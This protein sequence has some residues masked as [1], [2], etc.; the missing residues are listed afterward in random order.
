MGFTPPAPTVFAPPPPAL[1]L[2]FGGIGDRVRSDPKKCL[3]GLR[4]G[5]KLTLRVRVLGGAKEAKYPSDHVVEWDMTFIKDAP[6]PLQS[7]IVQPATSNRKTD[8]CLEFGSMEVLNTLMKEGKEAKRTE[9]VSPLSL[10]REGKLRIKGNRMALF[11]L[12][13]VFTGQKR[14]HTGFVGKDNDNAAEEAGTAQ[15]SCSEED[16]N[17]IMNL[18]DTVGNLRQEVEGQE[19]LINKMLVI[20]DLESAGITAAMGIWIYPLLYIPFFMVICLVILL[21]AVGYTHHR[22]SPV[23]W[24][25]FILIEAVA[26]YVGCSSPTSSIR[27]SLLVLYVFFRI[28]FRYKMAKLRA[29]SMPDEFS[30]AFWEITHRITAEE[31]YRSILIVQGLY[32]KLGQAM[33]GRADI[34]PKPFTKQL[35]KLQDCLGQDSKDHVIETLQHELKVKSYMDI[36]SDF[37]FNAVASASI[38]QV[39]KARL[40][41]GGGV[42]A[43]KLQHKGVEQVMKRDA[44]LVKYLFRLTGWAFPKQKPVFDAITEFV[45]RMEPELDFTQEAECLRVANKTIQSAGELSKRVS[46]PYPVEGLVTRRVLV[47]DWIQASRVPNSED[48]DSLDTEQRLDVANSM[49]YAFAH[50]MLVKGEFMCDPH[51]GNF[52]VKPR[53]LHK[54]TS[55]NKK[56]PFEY[57]VTPSKQRW[58]ED[59]KEGKSGSFDNNNNNNNNTYDSDSSSWNSTRRSETMLP[60]NTGT[61][62]VI[63][64]FGM[65]AKLREEAREGFCELL[66]AIQDGVVERMLSALNKI[67]IRLNKISDKDA[68]N[69]MTF[70]T[71]YYRDTAPAK[72][73]RAKFLEFVKAARKRREVEKKEGKKSQMFFEKVPVDWVYYNRTYS[74]LRG[75]N[76]DDGDDDDEEEEEEEEEDGDGGSD[77]TRLH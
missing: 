47:M 29:Q 55:I 20:E 66:L 65:S 15:F 24:G 69:I 10:I 13:S 9:G 23:V 51:P 42:V 48:D 39:H 28:A 72:E 52:L 74:L 5:G 4:N 62:L 12:R 71:H 77:G 75:D 37:D 35:K 27:R 8:S 34:L 64:D 36:F 50:L 43:V 44:V 61:E 14:S 63:L 11:R 25:P 6:S 31:V 16:F 56:K 76:D 59:E 17:Q 19:A 46:I 58:K 1:E 40:R 22:F 73:N 30:D 45:K 49:V 18:K 54:T 60:W 33:S 38:A 32:I 67:G 3:Q 41:N 68:D 7:F 57:S 26:I 70:L 21:P 2:F 53:Q